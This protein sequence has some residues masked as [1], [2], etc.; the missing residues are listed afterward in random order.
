MATKLKRRFSIVL[1][2]VILLF[3]VVVITF[4][5]WITVFYPMPHQEIVFSTSYEYEID[6]YLT[7]AII[8]AESKYQTSAESPVGAKGLMQIMPETAKWISEQMGQESFDMES[9]HD[10]QTNIDFGCWY[11]KTLIDEFNGQIPLAVASYNAGI[12]T[13][14]GWLEEG[15]WNGD[16]RDM[17]DIPFP[18]TRNYIKN[19]LKN[20]E[21]YTAIYK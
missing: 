10:P 21:A 13:V 5:K 7:F 14:N 18:E 19:V 16:P 11:I 15:K 4:P 17:Q 20:Y 2:T 6:P 9:L 12:G 8:R 3:L 1:W